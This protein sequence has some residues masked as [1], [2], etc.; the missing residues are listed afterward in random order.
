MKYEQG[1]VGQ[2]ELLLI[3]NQS[4]FTVVVF[5]TF[6]LYRAFSVINVPQANF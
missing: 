4:L 3:K 1:A 5:K 2:F 6:C